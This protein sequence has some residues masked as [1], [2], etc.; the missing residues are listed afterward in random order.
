MDASTLKF[1][2]K[3]IGFW[4]NIPG[5]TL[6]PTEVANSFFDAGA[7]VIL[8]G[9]DTPEAT[10]VAV[11][12][13]EKGEAVWVVP[14]DYH[15]ACELAGDICIG[16]PYFNWGPAYV[17]IIQS[18]IDGKFEQK[19]DWNGPDW[20][21]INNMDTTAV[22]FVQGPALSDEDKANLDKFIAGMADGPINLYTGPINFQDGTP[23]LKEG[24]T[25]TDDQICGICRRS[26]W[27]A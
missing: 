25:A 9:I 16:V 19:W 23:Y 7:D 1:D 13:A 22:G 14:Y 2:V 24:E 5:V 11:Q 4:F 18:A 12:R 27:K 6:D 10:T 3:W 17:G 20:T 8:S 21:D 26:C 15:D